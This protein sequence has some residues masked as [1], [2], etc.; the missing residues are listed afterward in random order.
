MLCRREAE[1]TEISEKEYGHL[2]R[3]VSFEETSL[4][5]GYTRMDGDEF[6]PGK[7]IETVW[8]LPDG[9]LLQHQDADEQNGGRRY[10]RGTPILEDENDQ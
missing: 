5:A 1:W 8:K 2:C 6:G 9:K 10:W 7:L 4:Y 3:S